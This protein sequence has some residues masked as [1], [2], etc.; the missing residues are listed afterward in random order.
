MYPYYQNI[1]PAQQV[2]Q[3]NG[4]QSVDSIQMAPNSS[5]LVMDTTAPIVWLCVSD[6]VGRVTATPYDVT[7]HIDAPAPDSVE[8]RLN[9]IENALKRM[10][11]KLNGKPDDADIERSKPKKETEYKRASVYDGDSLFINEEFDKMIDA[12]GKFTKE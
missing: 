6:G 3:V 4:K 10:E 11:D 9:A 1:L 8:A 7:K 12:L 2:L 5:V